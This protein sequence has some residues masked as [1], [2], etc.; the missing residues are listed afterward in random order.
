MWLKPIRLAYEEAAMRST[1]TGSSVT[2][3][4]RVLATWAGSLGLAAAT[5]VAPAAAQQPEPSGLKARSTTSQPQES[6]ATFD[7]LANRI[8]VGER[9][10]VTDTDGHVTRG[11][12]DRL[13]SSDLTL[14]ANG[15]QRFE[16]DGIS[17]IRHRQRDS[18]K[19]GAFI[20]LGVGGGMATAW[21]IGAL[22]DD[23]GDIDA[24]VECSEGF[25]FAGLGTLIGAGV[26]AIIPGKLSVIYRA[27]SGPGPAQ[28]HRSL[29]VVPVISTHRFMLMGVVRP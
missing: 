28:A 23:S 11:R 25:I 16:A 26:D 6:V 20:G 14:D 29:S 18:V 12:L 8:A 27:T 24:A 5:L 10:W 19:N 17:L 2:A 4:I 21:C 13:T 3:N 7:Q 9:L 1:I 22:A 15:T